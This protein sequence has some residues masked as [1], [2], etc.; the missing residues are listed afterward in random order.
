VRF[1][2]FSPLPP[3]RSGIAA[4]TAEVLPALL[5]CLDGSRAAPVDLDAPDG[6]VPRAADRF[7]AGTIGSC[8]TGATDEPRPGQTDEGL[9][10]AIDAFVG[11]DAELGWNAPTGVTVHPAHDFVWRHHVQPYDLVVYQTG[12]AWCHD[13][14]WPYLFRWPGLVV[15]HDGQ[16][17]HARAWSLL[18]RQRSAAYR[19]ELAHDRPDLPRESAEIAISGFAGPIYY[20]WPM[21]RAVVGSA[22][23]VAVHGAGLAGQVAEQYA[24][25]APLVIPMGVAD[26]RAAA[27]PT[28]DEIRARHAVAPDAF[29]FAAFGGITPEKRV[30]EGLRA[31]AA[32]SRVRHDAHVLLVGERASHFD[33]DAVAHSLGVA[34][35]V[36]VTGYVPDRELPGY[37]AAADAALCL[38]WPTTGEAS[39][40]W[41]RAIAAGLPTVIT[42]LAHQ[43]DLPVLDPRTWTVQ[44]AS[45]SLAQPAPVAIAIDI[46]DEEHSLRLALRRL[47]TDEEL[48][49]Q[50]GRAARE[51]YES[52]HTIGR[53]VAGYR[54]AIALATAS[55]APAAILPSHLR[56]DPLAH[57]RELLDP[58]GLDP[59]A[60]LR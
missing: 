11:S 28:R 17:H 42:D 4:Y 51:H 12:N 15:L 37:L 20:L 44:H 33:V 45:R 21:L 23:A 48:C 27:S 58:F 1:A 43:A 24:P 10:D 57:V 50:L 16:L 19:A 30:A 47:A 46:L 29:V 2:W 13:Y 9:I 38:R 52:Q 41:L 54:R 14:A 53:M 5:G 18:Q 40:S 56:P 3:V 39:A 7:V 22:R 34:D 6:L 26:P 60:L 55:T 49:R 32:V 35:R 8:V 25:C 31:V 36:T 59:E